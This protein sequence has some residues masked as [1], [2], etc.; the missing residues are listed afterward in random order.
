MKRCKSG[1]TMVELMVVCGLLML[2]I[3]PTYKI[4]SH[5]SKSAIKGV[6]RNSIIMEGQNILSQIK[7][8][9]VESAFPFSDAD[10]Q[11]INV[12]NIFSET[13]DADGNIKI[14]FYSFSGGDYEQQVRPTSTGAE[15]YRRLNRI[16]Y[17]L[18]S[19]PGSIFKVL[20]RIVYLHPHHAGYRPEGKKRVLSDKVNF[21]E[22]RPETIDSAGFS[23]S[24]FRASLQLFDQDANADKSVPPN[25]DTMFIAEFCETINPLIL[26]AL[27]NNPGLNRNWY[28]DPSATD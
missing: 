20:E 14:T 8:D 21:F 18:S 16:E 17:R 6:Q 3:L 2:I 5:G 13:S 27:V 15:S 11:D 12:N 25:P 22:I 23:R 4:L 26:N 24:F 10:T 28:T 9:L 1:F 19:K 7:S